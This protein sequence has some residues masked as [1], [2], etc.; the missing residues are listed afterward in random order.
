MVLI[1]VTDNG[2]VFVKWEAVPND[3]W[4]I[5]E[6]ETLDI[7]IDGWLKLY[8]NPQSYDYKERNIPT[9]GRYVNGQYLVEDSA[10]T[11]G[12]TGNSHDFSIKYLNDHYW[13]SNEVYST[14]VSPFVP[15]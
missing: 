4:V 8:Y 12:K 14:G 1:A 15:I 2:S 10:T 6:P 3:E 5:E 7:G 13:Y 9:Y 11:N